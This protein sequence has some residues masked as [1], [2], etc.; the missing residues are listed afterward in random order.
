[1]LESPLKSG[2]VASEIDTG[3]GGAELTVNVPVA[4]HAVTAAVVGEA[5]PCTE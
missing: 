1:M 2:L 3:W 5:S 4:D